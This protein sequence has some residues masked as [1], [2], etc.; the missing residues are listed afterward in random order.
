MINKQQM[1]FSPLDGEDGK[2]DYNPEAI[3]HIGTTFGVEIEFALA[4]LYEDQKEK[5]PDPEEHD[6]EVRTMS[7][8]E[9]EQCM[10]DGTVRDNC[11]L[12]AWALYLLWKARQ[13]KT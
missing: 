2:L 13:S 7:I 9:F 8:P 1:T 11:T 5:D 3:S 6:L 4:T 12:S 10:L